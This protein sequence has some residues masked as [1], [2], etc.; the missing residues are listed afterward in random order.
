MEIIAD[1]FHNIFPHT[2]LFC[3]TLDSQRPA[4]ALV[5][6]QDDQELNWR[7]I[8]E[9]CAPLQ[10]NPSLNSD[11]L[12]RDCASVARLYLGEWKRSPSENAVAINTLGNLLI[13]L[14]AC[15]EWLT[16]SP[17]TK[18]LYGPRWLKFCH[19]RRAE[20]A[21]D[22]L[23]MNSPLTLSSLERADNLM[24]EVFLRQTRSQPR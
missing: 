4:L 15:R 20:M 19:E 7:T 23:P 1:T 17:G 13:E 22:G 24:H 8:A 14:D 11:P 9:L 18:Y 2:Y 21:A 10:K 12:L 16:V 6:F 3:N 5:G